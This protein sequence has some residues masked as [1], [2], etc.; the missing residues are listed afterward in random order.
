MLVK[1]N[2]AGAALDPDPKGEHPPMA[3]RLPFLVVLLALVVPLAFAGHPD[4]R[5]CG[6]RRASCEGAATPTPRLD[7]HL[8]RLARQSRA[9]PLRGGIGNLPATSNE[10]TGAAKLDV[11]SPASQAY[12]AF[13]AERRDEFLPARGRAPRPRARSR[14][15][16]RCRPERP[17][18]QAHATVKP[19]RSPTLPGVKHVEPRAGPRSC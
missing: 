10:Q 18:R 19:P 3:R 1:G 16:L 13:L 4:R 14:L 17:H 11:N 15:H 12:L 6:R 9:C 7:R 8:Y 5:A 2:S